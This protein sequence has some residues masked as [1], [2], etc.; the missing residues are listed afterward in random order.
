MNWE[1]D[2]PTWPLSEL[3]RRVQVRPHR[4]HVQD[5]GSGPMILLLH[6]AGAST[7]SWR[8]VL[9]RLAEIHHVAAVDLPGQ[10]FTRMGATGRN[11]L[12][13]MAEDLLAL[14]ED[15]GWRPAA[16]VGHSAGAALALRLSHRL[17]DAEGAPPRVIGFNAALEAFDGL[18][19]WLFPLLAKFLATTPMAARLFTMGGSHETRARALIEN[20]G[21]YL[22]DVGIALYARLIADRDHVDATLRMMSQW[23]LESL[24]EE[25]Q[26][27]VAPTLFL[28]GDRDKAVP[29][30][31]SDR[32]AARMPNAEVR[33]WT[34][35]GHLMHEE[36][37]ERAV[38]EILGFLRAS[39]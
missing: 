26:T 33:T 39:E 20:T 36:A 14:C 18:A 11:G 13:T 27:T 1:R 19:G 30:R 2:L 9:P 17:R 6:G 35:L 10:G 5:A 7:H 34:G 3:S 22:D 28:T 24:L 25:L 38:N 4:W 21:S 8:D 29:P 23:S 16:L 32:A 15:Q 31:T 37:P 12:D